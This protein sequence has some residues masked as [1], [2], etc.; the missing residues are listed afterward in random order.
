MPDNQPPGPPYQQQPYGAPPPPGQQPYQQPYGQQPYQQQPYANPQPQPP[1]QQPYQ[2][3]Y[4]QQPPYGQQQ[5]YATPQPPQQPPYAAGQQQPPYGAAPYQQ[6]SS[7]QRDIWETKGKRAIAFGAVW[8]VA[9]LLITIITYSA[10]AGGGVYVVAWGPALYGIY[11][12]FSGYR[13]LN[14]ARS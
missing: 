6:V 10:A 9:G 7:D 13:L 12:I 5:P 8:L 14:K 2:Q 4:G 1:Y 3:P 11:R